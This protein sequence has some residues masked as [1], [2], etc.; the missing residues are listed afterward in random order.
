MSDNGCTALEITGLPGER[1]G[2]QGSQNGVQGFLEASQQVWVYLPRG[3]W[4]NAKWCAIDTGGGGLSPG[5]PWTL[6]GVCTLPCL[7]G[8][9]I[10]KEPIPFPMAYR[11]CLRMFNIWFARKGTTER[12]NRL[13][14][15][16]NIHRRA[17]I[18]VDWNAMRRALRKPEGFVNGPAPLP[19]V[20]Q[21]SAGPA[22][23][24]HRHT[25]GS[26]GAQGAASDQ[27]ERWLGSQVTYLN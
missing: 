21:E 17:T 10:R 20:H 12:S 22:H 7:Y 3:D 16:T 18:S 6:Q 1:Q 25:R 26:R 11:A 27:D 9:T 4:C 8:R 24:G 23:T 2:I 15:V 5:Y 13:L 14:M 19:W